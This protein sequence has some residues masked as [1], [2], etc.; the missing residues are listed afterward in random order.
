MQSTALKRG[1]ILNENL[2][3]AVIVCAC[4]ISFY[5]IKA[6][7]LLLLPLSSMP[8]DFTILHLWLELQPKMPIA[9]L[10]S[11]NMNSCGVGY[12]CKSD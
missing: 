9:T 3:T 2:E 10:N 12:T 7:H 1:S 11:R 8:Y 6:G 5:P 4:T